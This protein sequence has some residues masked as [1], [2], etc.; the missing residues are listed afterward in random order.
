MDRYFYLISQL[1]VLVFDKGSSI[2]L[3]YFLEEAE[4]WLSPAV[5][6]QLTKTRLFQTENSK[7]RLRLIREFVEFEYQFRKELSGWRKARKSGQ[8]I[9]PAMFDPVLV[10]EGNPLE[11]EKK[12]LLLRWNF[13]EQKEADH[14]FDFEFLVIYYLKLQILNHL[15]VFN[16]EK[17]IEVLQKTVDVHMDEIEAEEN[18]MTA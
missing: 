9:K 8:E 13:L 4:K 18:G 3:D 1:P 6:R 10:K 11:V 7:Y 12:L 17:G 16:K 5:Y 15:Q 2:S 14:H